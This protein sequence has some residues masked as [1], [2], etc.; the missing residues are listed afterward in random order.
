[1]KWNR[2]QRL[3]ANSVIALILQLVNL[4]SGFLVPRLILARYGSDVNGLVNS[5]SQFLGAISLLDLGVGTVVESTLYK[6]LA[7]KN[8]KL[9]SEIVVSATKFFRR[10]A[11]ILIIYTIVLMGIYPSLV[12]D[13]FDYIYTA[14]LIGALSISSFVQYYFGI[15]NG[16]ILSADQ[17]G[18]IN[19]FAQIIT[20]VFN[21]IISCILIKLNY[22]I[23]IVK[24]V[25]SI[26]FLIRPLLLNLYVKKNYIVDPYVQYK[27]EPI[28]QKWDGVA[29]HL[30]YYVLT[31]TDNIV[32][33]IFSSLENVSIYSVYNL[34]INGVKSLLLALTQGFKSVMGDMLA[35]G[36]VEALNTFFGWTEWM[37][38]TV[39]M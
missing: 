36:E 33:T 13:S 29:Q 37:L 14:T 26:I 5:I 11:F 2:K 25:T 21:T 32:L 10:L 34:V 9:F 4:L 1:M 31:G 39:T 15:V 19:S 8:H 3:V 23:Q 7:E 16:I 17:R 24:L 38:H 28:K 20:I 27:E 30:A 6:P 35:R 18:F 12:N 22:S